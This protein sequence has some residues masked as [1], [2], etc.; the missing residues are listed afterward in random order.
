MVNSPLHDGDVSQ[1]TFQS[2]FSQLKKTFE[3]A[4]SRWSEW[5]PKDSNGDSI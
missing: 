4:E 1:A 5:Q 3:E 2:A